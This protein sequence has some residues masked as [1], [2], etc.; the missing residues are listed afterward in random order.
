MKSE[1]PFMAPRPGSAALA[2]S[3]NTS[4]Q[5]NAAGCSSNR[6]ALSPFCAK[7]HSVYRNYGHPTAGPVKQAYYI[8]YRKAVGDLLDAN[9]EHQGLKAA[10]GYVSSWMQQATANEKAYK[11]AAD[12]AGL[13]R[14]GVTPRQVLIEVCSFYTYLSLH[15]RRPLP[16]ARSESFAMSRAVLMLAPRV[17]RYTAAANAKDGSGYAL[18]PKF[19]ALDHIGAH[20]RTVLAYVLGNVADAVANRDA[21][22]AETLEALRA[23]L[24]PPVAVYLAEAALTA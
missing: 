7:H 21:Q 1:V 17:R 3:R 6:T 14:H 19:A 4:R 2:M 20:L 11:G 5:C 23:P 22:A 16:D 18:R 9:E 10:L 24:K 8:P 15:G 12:V 13:V